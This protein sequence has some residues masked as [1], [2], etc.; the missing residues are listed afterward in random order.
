MCPR[1]LAWKWFRGLAD[2]SFLLE[3]VVVDRG[4]RSWIAHFLGWS[5]AG[6]VSLAVWG[7][8]L[9]WLGTLAWP[10][11]LGVAVVELGPASVFVD[12]HTW[13]VGSFLG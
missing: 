1:R 7:W 2:D 8:R 9:A 3:S 5:L 11:C 13:L 10:V 6:C 12:Q 4:V